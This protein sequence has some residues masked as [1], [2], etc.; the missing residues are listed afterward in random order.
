MDWQSYAALAIV[1]LTVA[2]FIYSG[3]KRKAKQGGS[4]GSGCG[5]AGKVDTARKTL[6]GLPIPG[7]GAGRK[8]D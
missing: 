2:L 8:K 3:M 4:C 6:S 7:G 5:C 1:G